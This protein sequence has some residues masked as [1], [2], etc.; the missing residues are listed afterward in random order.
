MRYSSGRVRKNAWSRKKSPPQ[1]RQNKANK[2]GSV[3][4]KKTAALFQKQPNGGIIILS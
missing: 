2:K 4:E 3:F 1:K